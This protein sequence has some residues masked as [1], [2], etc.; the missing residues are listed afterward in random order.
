MDVNV[1][2]ANI[3]TVTLRLRKRG[4][5]YAH[6]SITIPPDLIKRNDLI[7]GDE[8]VIAFLEKAKTKPKEESK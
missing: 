1:E 6:G 5:K 4:D 3:Q 7:D 8:I 2:L